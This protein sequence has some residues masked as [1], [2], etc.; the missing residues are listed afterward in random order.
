MI[1]NMFSQY[2]N[3]EVLYSVAFYNYKIILTEYNYKIY[4]K[5]LLIILKTFK[6]W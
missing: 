3:K 1:E 4:N 5:K 6:N 2:N